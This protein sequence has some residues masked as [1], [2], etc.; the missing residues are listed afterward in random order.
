MD[1]G[2]FLEVVPMRLSKLWLIILVGL[3]ILAIGVNTMILTFLTDRY[4]GDYLEESYKTHV[5]QILE[6]TRNALTSEDINYKQ[7]AVQL[8]SHLT[9]PIIS[10]KL[11][12]PNGQKLIEVETDYTS[13]Y[14]YKGMM[15]MMMNRR[16]DNISLE[17]HQF[18][19]ISN[20]NL[21]ATMNIS[22]HS[23]SENSFV[24]QRFQ[25]NLFVNSLLSIAITLIMAV[26]IGVYISRK[27][28]HSLKDTE[29]LARDIQLGN[30][31]A[32]KPTKIKEINGI[33][34][35]LKELNTRLKMKQMT[36]KSLLDQLVH[37][38]RT[39]LTIL[40][41]HLEGI[42]DGV[43][44]MDKHEI[45]ICQNQISDITHIISNMST[46]IDAGNDQDQVT[47][48]TFE[49]WGLLKQIQQGLSAQF[50]QKD[51]EL[52]VLFADNFKLTTD[53]YKL[54]QSIY[55]ILTNAYK[56]TEAKGKVTISYEVSNQWLKIIIEDT[57]LGIMEKDLDKIFTAY[58]RGSQ[59]SHE[60]GDGMGLFI[61][62]KNIDCIGGK[63]N[64]SSKV[65]IGSRFT[66]EIPMNLKDHLDKS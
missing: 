24:A 42:E 1:K 65:N 9:D 5:N 11:Y 52:D 56:Y 48:E 15:G 54:S 39:P 46:L 26:F 12:N 41:S 51:L 8:E 66:I 53:R 22:N 49:F 33:R 57:G 34:E 7:M 32:Y 13:N 6:Y 40:Q 14:D 29:R 2:M 28:T 31:F 27:M 43:I 17:I 16:N 63:L 38:T 59:S 58:Y 19:I 23:I 47:I 21:I 44:D 35:S 62:K 20:G 10:I 64:V 25:G 4:F 36:R 3:T 61:A 60:S 30:D 18:D 45:S 50:K 37:Q 55:N